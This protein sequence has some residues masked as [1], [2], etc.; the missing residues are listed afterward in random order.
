MGMILVVND[1]PA[2][3]FALIEIL[4]R[5]GFVVHCATS[6]QEALAHIK[7]ISPDILL[8]DAEIAGECGLDLVSTLRSMPEWTDKPI[9][10]TST[11]TSSEYQAAAMK[12]GVDTFI[13][14]PFSRKDLHAQIRQFFPLP[15]TTPL[16]PSK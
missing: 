10:M 9:I 5:D 11:Q 12:A 16:I 1:E 3:S 4:R 6:C 13:T 2:F 7:T 8:I 14:K 15:A